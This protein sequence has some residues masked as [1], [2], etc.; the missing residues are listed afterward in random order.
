MSRSPTRTRLNA[1]MSFPRAASRRLAPSRAEPDRAHSWQPRARSGPRSGL[2]GKRAII[3]KLPRRFRTS[4][5]EED[6]SCPLVRKGTRAKDGHVSLRTD[7]ESVRRVKSTTSR[8]RDRARGG[9]RLMD[10]SQSDVNGN[11][12]EKLIKVT[13]V[14]TRL[15]H[16]ERRCSRAH[17]RRV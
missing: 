6:G 10:P 1:S 4:A 13:L 17:L 3:D 9:K 2:V 11:T 16:G 12:Q 7:A 8:N 5:A 14:L 15:S